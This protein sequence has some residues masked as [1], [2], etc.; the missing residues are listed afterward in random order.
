[1]T[2]YAVGMDTSPMTPAEIRAIGERLYGGRHGWK[3][4]LAEKLGVTQETISRWLGGGKV[5]K[6]YDRLLRS[7]V[8]G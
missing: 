3:K 4:E 8:D 1:M 6:P 2:C 7:L 5:S